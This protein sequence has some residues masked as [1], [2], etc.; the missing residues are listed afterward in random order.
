MADAT[1]TSSQSLSLPQAA[2]RYSRRSRRLTATLL[3]SLVP[4][5]GVIGFLLATAVHFG[6]HGT[7]EWERRM[8]ENG[9]LWLVGIQGFIMG[10]GHIFT[11]DRV[12]ESIGW[13]KGNPFQFEVGLASISYGTLGAFA[14][15]FGPDWWL[16]AIVAYSI[17][18][19]GAAAG[20]VRELV[21]RGNRSPGNAG[22][23]F[24]L[25]IAVP[26]FLIALYVLY[27]IA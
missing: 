3:P 2:P 24:V 17:F 1:D 18:Y 7:G 10:S 25:D 20:H 26:I 9:L 5:V 12:A 23:V 16:A 21:F 22:L 4:L 13:P 11:P 8:L 27:R 19:L 14:S 6:L 15:S